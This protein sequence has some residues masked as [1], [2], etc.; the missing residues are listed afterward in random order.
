MSR[1]K[2][3]N[4]RPLKALDDNIEAE[5]DESLSNISYKMVAVADHIQ[6]NGETQQDSDPDDFD[7][8]G[9][10]VVD[11][12]RQPLDD[13][14]EKDTTDQ[15]RSTSALH[16]AETQ[17][18]LDLGP[19][20]SAE[21]SPVVVSVA[22]QEDAPSSQ[23]ITD[24]HHQSIDDHLPLVNDDS[25][26][27]TSRTPSI[28]SSDQL[29][30]GGFSSS[31]S[32]SKTHRRGVRILPVAS[33]TG[34]SR[35]VC[36][37]CN[38]TL[39]SSHEL[40]VHIRSHNTHTGSA[41]QANSCTICGKSLSSQSSLD[42]HML[43]HSGERPF[44]CKYCNM[45]F[46]TNGNMHRHMRIHTKETEAN[47]HSC[48]KVQRKRA[49]SWKPKVNSFIHIEPASSKP[50]GGLTRSPQLVG[51]DLLQG[52]SQLAKELTSDSHTRY[53]YGK[54]STPKTSIAPGVKRSFNFI[55]VS[56]GEW[57]M[58][59]I[60]RNKL[61]EEGVKLES[62]IAQSSHQATPRSISP[63]ADKSAE[64]ME[65]F[66][67]E[68]KEVEQL[69]CPACNKAF[70][71]KY[72]LENHI[73]ESHPN[74]SSLKCHL[75][76]MN[77]HTLRSLSLH[78]TLVHAKAR[79]TEKED[80]ECKEDVRAAAAAVIGFY[81]LSFVDFSIKKFSLIAKSWCEQN[82]RKSSS[83]YHH[84]VC[85]ECSKAFPCKG[86]LKLHLNTHSRAKTSQCP[87]CEC[88][89]MT[90]KELHLH[91][92]KH[93]SDKAFADVQ[94]PVQSNRRKPA[95]D[96]K[97]EEVGKHDFLAS[98]GLTA[99]VES[100]D[101]TEKEHKPVLSGNN[102][103]VHERKENNEY[104]A[105]L[106]QIFSPTVS[107]IHPSKKMEP[108][109]NDNDF[110]NIAKILQTS[111]T[112]GLLAGLPGHVAGLEQLG[113]LNQ[114]QL[115]AF[116]PA[117]LNS[118]NHPSFLSTMPAMM[119]ASHMMSLANQGDPSPLSTPP[120]SGEGNSSGGSASSPS[121]DSKI[122]FP[123]KYCDLVFPNYRALKSHTRT[124]LGLSP[125]KCNLCSYSSADKSTLIR[126][127]RTHNGERP[128][129]CR[130]CDFAFT[131]KANCERHVRKKHG[132]IVKEDIEM[133]IG[134]NK[135]VTEHSAMDSF[136]SPDT[137]CKYCG[138]DFK[139]FRALKHHLRSHSSCRQKPFQC[140]RCDVGFSTKANC[141]RHVQKQHTEI[142]QNHIEQYIV[143]H[144][145]LLGEGSDRSD[146]ALSDDNTSQELPSHPPAAHSNSRLSMTPNSSRAES[147][148]VI[149]TE[150]I[151]PDMEDR[152]LDFSVKSSSANSTPSVT[153]RATPN[154]K[155]AK[156]LGDELPMDLSIKKKSESP[157]M[158]SNNKLKV[159]YD[160][161]L[162]Q[163]QFCPMGFSS[164]RVL[165]RHIWQLHPQIAEI[166]GKHYFTPILPSPADKSMTSGNLRL[167]LKPPIGDGALDNRSQTPKLN[168][169]SEMKKSAILDKIKREASSPSGSLQGNDPN[170]DLAS[171][172]KI[173]D[174]TNA[175]HFQLYLQENIGDSD[176]QDRSEAADGEY[177]D[178][179]MPEISD[180]DREE[181]ALVIAEDPPVLSPRSKADTNSETRSLNGDDDMPDLNKLLS[182]ELRQQIQAAQKAEREYIPNHQKIK[183]DNI[184]KKRNSYADSP[185][186]LQC[187][188]CTRTFPWV[189]SLT[190]H[191]LTHTGQKPFKCPKCP[192]T[193]STKSNR[194]RHLIRK[195]GVN[196]M[197][198]LSRQTMDRPYKCHLC[199][200]SSF[201]TQGNL[202]KHYK[203]RHSGCSLPESLIDLDKAVTTGLATT[204]SGEERS[205]ARDR[206]LGIS[207]DDVLENSS[208]AAEEQLNQSMENERPDDRFMSITIDS[209]CKSDNEEEDDLEL[210]TPSMP[211]MEDINNSINTSLN[212]STKQFTGSAERQINPERDNYN[213]DKITDCWN[214]GEKFVS[215]KL[216]VRHL[217]EHNIDLPFKCYLCDASYDVRLDCLLHQEKF[218]ASDWVILKDKNKVDNV[219]SFSRHMDKVVENNCNKVDQGVI[220]EIPGQSADDPKMEVV[221]ADYMQRKVYCSLCPKRFWSLQDLRRH[222]RSHTGERPFECD[223][224]QKRFTLKHSMM[225]HRKKHMET[226][227]LSPSDDE[228]IN[229]STDDLSSLKIKG[230][231]LLPKPSPSIL[232]KQSTI[233]IQLSQ[234]L[235][236]RPMTNMSGIPVI[237]AMPTMT[238]MSAMPTIHL[239]NSYNSVSING[240]KAREGQG[241]RANSIISKLTPSVTATLGSAL[242]SMGEGKDNDI[243]HSLLG[244]ELGS[245][246]SMLDSADS[247]ARLLGV[248]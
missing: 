94:K 140:T 214:C 210:S 111:A 96:T 125:Y 100:L 132:K 95:K 197:D 175:N 237:A 83:V 57:P 149:K 39:S 70:I 164:Q 15:A 233:P 145:P 191:L 248:N 47:A 200:F 172:K 228:D 44:R 78:K 114:S 196:M 215:R 183:G 185:H 97:A 158:L 240:D 205:L 79:K 55:N 135:Y 195:H 162:H 142:S 141:I 138:V 245:I 130:V 144:E 12:S 1:R 56:P 113:L 207:Q 182:S 131:T 225:R 2:Q 53:Q 227:S 25:N 116:M 91:M 28:S 244:V 194:E 77:F 5:Q 213:V 211:T 52:S 8:Y 161:T 34:E 136:H 23:P 64:D 129:Q 18:Q 242:G 86:A 153:P 99:N 219:D 179:D 229:P 101:V 203:E 9:P 181:S 6:L 163:C 110:A 192:V 92:I 66:E 155:M 159:M 167:P 148:L 4:P 143:V 85:K 16:L 10:L 37:I 102:F 45:S 206:A 236:I 106:G 177:E 238:S 33:E 224:C 198:P 69:H 63:S 22:G 54:T 199:V 154:K 193:F 209:G 117:F 71:C 202:L 190:R 169:N 75:C 121:N 173:I 32:S 107:P 128:F 120:P 156:S 221:S 62:E 89:Y 88:D 112:G 220:L 93:M 59:P 226:G 216:L 90:T 231:R 133:A 7:E 40:T 20:L 134:Y 43:V 13:D 223:I 50:V 109:E 243:L 73:R 127:L 232:V 146:G 126:H 104:F 24:L 65:V 105:K 230:P 151:D 82:A 67:S 174:T 41:S 49:P 247:A 204:L 189:S 81:D 137:V 152:P 166:M 171:V 119:N 123:C 46:T 29:S 58:P 246:D 72:G 42:R 212:S 31:I 80:D 19:H 108:T 150:P 118:Y 27:S 157:V 26:L 218:H 36:P 35:Y 180:T 235:P 122:A 147:P 184:K 160:N 188:Y 186:K 124:H 76:H 48:G 87:L 98:F 74:F 241:Q 187:P 208:Y 165:D 17:A 60:K 170:C 30:P 103:K 38:E 178:L 222:M 68:D 51:N 3:A 11:T 234:P 239:S 201:S 217:K 115:A 176:S 21:L 14:D 139:F 168:N 61:F 84:F